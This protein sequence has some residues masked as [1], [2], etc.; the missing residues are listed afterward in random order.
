MDVNIYHNATICGDWTLNQRSIGTT[1]FHIVTASRC[2]L[3][4]PGE[5]D[6]LLNYGDLIIFP[7]EPAHTMRPVTSDGE[8]H[9]IDGTGLLCAE[10]HFSHRSGT[11]ILDSLPSMLVIRYSESKT[12]LGPVL[13]LIIA[14]NEKYGAASQVLINKLSELLFTYSLRHYLVNNPAKVGLLAVYAHPQI[15]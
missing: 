15:A 2:F 4:V 8:T 14:E 11:Y 6:G 7:R 13:E 9:D 12:W 3:T 1:C 10:I 5:F